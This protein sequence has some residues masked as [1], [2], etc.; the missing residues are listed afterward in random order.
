M[1]KKIQLSRMGSYSSIGL[2]KWDSLKSYFNF[3]PKECFEG[4]LFRAIYHIKSDA[5]DEAK[6]FLDDARDY[7]DGELSSV[8]VESYERGYKSFLTCQILSELEEAI[9]FKLYPNHQNTIKKTWQKRI[10][11]CE[12]VVSDWRRILDL[13]SIVIKPH[14]NIETWLKLSS[15]S[16]KAGRFTLCKNIFDKLLTQIEVDQ[17]NNHTVPNIHPFLTTNYI[18]YMWYCDKKLDAFNLLKE[19][20]TNYLVTMI[21]SDISSNQ[22]FE[23][24]NL[25]KIMAKSY[26]RLGIWSRD[27]DINEHDISVSNGYFALAVENNKQYYKAWQ[28]WAKL[29]YEVALNYKHDNILSSDCNMENNKEGGQN[30]PGTILCHV[31]SAVSAF[32]KSIK[33]CGKN[34]FQDTLRLLTL[35]FEFGEYQE[36]YDSLIDNI[37]NVKID[38]WLQVLPQLIARIDTPKHKVRRMIQHLLVKVGN[39]HP[40]AFIYPLMVSSKSV[41]DIRSSV[42]REVLNS[43]SIHYPGLVEQATMISNE[44]IRVSILWCEDWCYVIEEASKLFLNDKN[45]P[46]ALALIDSMYQ[47]MSVEVKTPIEIAFIQNNMNELNVALK[48]RNN[49]SISNNIKDLIQAWNIYYEVYKRLSKQINLI[50]SI[51]LQYAS[52]KLFTCRNLILVIPG[53]YQPHIKTICIQNINPV[54]TVIDSKQKPRKLSVRGDDGKTYDFLLKG[55]E[56]LRQDERIMQLFGLLNN[57]LMNNHETFKR[58]LEIKRYSVTPISTYSGL[59]GWVS[60][61]DTLHCL[62]KEYRNKNKILVKFE[63]NII[64][65]NYPQYDQ[66][67]PLHK[68]DLFERILELT[69][70]TDLA[71]SMWQKKYNIGSLV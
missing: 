49:F 65:K 2:G 37:K 59:I 26:L 38:N 34:S 50:N 29:N 16:M 36:V 21:K 20:T 18:K 61:C 19:F 40:Q 25:K 53:S 54:L 28:A 22:L 58:K 9:N 17:F 46:S 70:D 48:Y 71:E 10:L 11:K 45:I 3:I 4:S 57:I 63:N 66:L 41:N 42:V 56:D 12:K 39:H 30:V 6:K 5:C 60:D 35:W 24:V 13:R 15:I 67:D 32:F 64:N 44:L 62:I 68:I 33:F 1:S 27:D 47:K 51:D 43:V 52:P 31:V 8:L 55:K 69:T 14:E 7:L 23:G